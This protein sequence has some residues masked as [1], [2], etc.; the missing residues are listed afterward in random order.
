MPSSTLWT[1][2][3][4]GYHS[5]GK[6]GNSA[7]DGFHPRFPHPPFVSVF[8]QSQ[9]FSFVIKSLTRGLSWKTPHRL[10]A[11]S[12]K[13]QPSDFIRGQSGGVCVQEVSL[14]DPE[15]GAAR[16]N[17]TPQVAIHASPTPLRSPL[18]KSRCAGGGGNIALGSS[19]Q[20]GASAGERARALF[21]LKGE[22]R[23]MLTEVASP[24]SGDTRPQQRWVG[25]R[26]PQTL[27]C[28]QGDSGPQ[29]PSR[30]ARMS[31]SSPSPSWC[32][33]LLSCRA[34]GR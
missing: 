4:Q 1:A 20:A 15:G 14:V 17:P 2:V 13:N 29:K 11:F 32:F 9:S 18:L 21:G 27:C 19:V 7:T 8:S 30:A 28:C 25:A 33:Q 26:R 23:T 16:S 3:F 10:V 6:K 34:G 24:T 31:L 5:S 22:R 12:W